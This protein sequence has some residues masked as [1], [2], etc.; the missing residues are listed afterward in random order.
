MTRQP[1]THPESE[2]GIALIVVLLLLG[3][4]SGLVTGLAFNGQVESTMAHNEV[5]YAGARAAAE[6]G[7]NRAIEA[8]KHDSVTDFLAG[9]DGDAA[10]T[11]DNGSIAFL[12]NGT[13]PYGL[14]SDYSYTIHVYDDDD[15]ALYGGTALTSAQ[16]ANMGAEDGDAYVD[17]NDRLILRVTGFGPSGT[18]VTV[19]RIL[20]SVGVNSTTTT[21]TT[22][23]TNPG[24]LVGGDLTINGSPNLLG[25]NGSVHANGDL[26]ISGNSTTVTGDATAGGD[27]T[28]NENWHAGGAQG[29]GR[30]VV[31]VPDV[32]AS[33]YLDRATCV[34][35]ADGTKSPVGTGV[36]GAEWTFSGGTWSITGNSATA[37]TVY[38]NGQVTVSGNP[39]GGGA[40]AT[41]IQLS[42]IATGDISITG[43]PKFYPHASAGGL[44][45]VTDG[46]LRLAGNADLDYITTVYGQSLVRGQLDLSGNPDLRGQIIVQDV[47][48][49]GTLVDT[50]SVSG[51]PTITYNGSFADIE[52]TV[53]T[54]TTGP[55]TYTNN[56]SGWL[57]GQ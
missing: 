43:N 26:L 42:I 56:V 8:V 49:A 31:N 25:S 54:T 28:A 44:Q 21:T 55:T 29:G 4:L 50:N 13:S 52:S 47:S 53:T 6:A 22:T 35:N 12:L 45:L 40:K 15:P 34:L 37:G 24:L 32:Q 16:L 57:E 46:D 5:Y 3:V 36:C 41:P 7:M 1:L 48:G 19:S 23:I 9:A 30:P 17:T 11:A 27:F 20:E 18:S 14:G 2:R 33:N 39:P 51:N 38:V 10:V